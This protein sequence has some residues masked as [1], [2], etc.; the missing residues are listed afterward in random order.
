MVLLDSLAGSDMKRWPS[1]ELEDSDS[2]LGGELSSSFL[3]ASGSGL[4]M[5]SREKE[6]SETLLGGGV[7]DI[8][9]SFIFVALH[10]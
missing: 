5:M 4:L 3:V 2:V 10:P 7:E 6:F 8:I 9:E 1:A